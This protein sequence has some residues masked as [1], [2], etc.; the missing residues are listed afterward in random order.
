MEAVRAIRNIRAEMNV[1][2]GKKIELIFAADSA[3]EG[4]RQGEIYIKALCGAE[5]MKI[6][7]PA[8]PE[9]DASQAAVAHVRGIDI[10]LPL[11]GL[12]DL[13][14]ET[15]RLQKEVANMDKEIKRL[16]GKLNNQGFLSK[17]P[18]DVVAGEKVKLADY[19]EKKASLLE[20]L[21]QLEK[22]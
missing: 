15:A 14:K 20:R 6:L 9:L 5:S 11:K 4:L 18:A 1:P 12:I 2:P 19:T 3:A 7:P 10:Y 8:S 21:A 17:A 16:E 13:D 22:M